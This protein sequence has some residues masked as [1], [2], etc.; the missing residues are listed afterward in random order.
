M[1]KI[2]KDLLNELIKILYRKKYLLLL[3]FIFFMSIAFALIGK[4]VNGLIGLYI[5]NFPMTVLSVLVTFIL[6]LIVFMVTADVFTA[7]QE[8][9]TIKAILTRPVS[10][11]RIY[12]SKFMAILIYSCMILLS[13][14]ISSLACGTILNSFMSISIG[15]TIVAYILSV[16]PLI[17]IIFFAITIS[18]ISRSTSGTVMISVLTYITIYVVTVIFPK[19]YPL[20]FTSYTSWYLLFIGSVIPVFNVLNII[21]LFLAY[22][23]I[24]FAISFWLFD[25]R[26]Y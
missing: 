17:P 15:S 12:I 22:S 21:V 11:I 18:Q 25:K 8:N 26:Q 10:R 23:L 14:F 1:I 6:P 7:E 13:G 20:S 19:T 24:F 9:G 16:F 3:M 2:K 4:F 5:S